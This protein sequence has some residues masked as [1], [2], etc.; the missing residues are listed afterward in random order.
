M[1]PTIH[2]TF[3]RAVAAHRSGR[4]VEAEQGY[5]ATLDANPAHIDALH[6]LGLLR[7]QQSRHHDAVSLIGCAAAS[8]PQDAALQLNLGNALKAIGR[9]DD[10]IRHFQHAL[11]LQPGFTAAQYN[12]GNAYATAGRHEDAVSAF[13]SVLQFQPTDVSASNNLGNELMVLGRPR[14]A[15]DIFQ[16]ALEF[17]PGHAQLHNNL[18]GAFNSLGIS[19]QAIVHFEAAVAAEPR[20]VA[21]HINLGNALHAAG[22]FTEAIAAFRA[23]LVLQPHQAQAWVAIGNAMGAMGHHAEALLQF[24]RALGVDPLCTNAWLNIGCAH[25]ELG[26]HVA[27]I[28]AFDEALRISPQLAAAHLYRAIATLTLGDFVR[29]LPGYEWRLQAME[30]PP[31]SAL[32]RWSGEPVA[33]GTLLIRAEQGFGDTLQFIRFVPLVA[34]RVA[35]VVLEVQAPL[36]PLLA[37]AART[38]G[39]TLIAQGTSHPG[40]DLQCPL[41]SLPYAL[42]TTFDTIPDGTPY[43]SV[44]DEYRR[45]WRDTLGASSKRKVGLAWSGRVRQHENRAVPLGALNPLFEIDDID[46][47][48]LQRDI[49]EQERALLDTHPHASRIHRFDQHVGDFADTAAIT[50]Q[51]D[52]VVSIDT[53]IAHLAGALRKPMWLMLPLAADWRWFAG[54]TDSPWYPGARLVRQTQPGAWEEVISTVALALGRI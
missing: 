46:W 31:A 12:L 47:I 42:G 45:K 3:D 44:P 30:Q 24:E 52:A 20:F 53:S 28:R 5:R 41:L 11:A 35:H 26:A 17:F 21:G 38:W 36:V 8:R 18:G 51:L 15:I 27:A 39:V 43:L 4:L 37:A 54:T 19:D 2:D 1:L 9:I 6:M 48:V 33:N 13:E 7:H 34:Q 22:R 29:G 25:L 23:A 50:E 40:I 49:S 32:T 10:A 16:R 14:E